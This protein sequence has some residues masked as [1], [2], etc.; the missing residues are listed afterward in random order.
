MRATGFSPICTALLS[1]IST[2]AAAPSLML[3]EVAA[4]IV[5]SF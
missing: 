2:S 5:P 1:R 4:V 3:D